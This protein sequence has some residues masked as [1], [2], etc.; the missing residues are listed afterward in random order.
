[1]LKVTRHNFNKSV[2]SPDLFLLVSTASINFSTCQLLYK[3]SFVI[4]KYI[5]TLL[6]L[7]IFWF[8]AVKRF[9]FSVNLLN[10]VLKYMTGTES[11][12]IIFSIN[13]LVVYFLINSVL[14][15]NKLLTEKLINWFCL[16]VLSYKTKMNLLHFLRSTLLSEIPSAF[17]HLYILFIYREIYVEII[18][19]LYIFSL[20]KGQG[21]V[22]IFHCLTYPPHS[23]LPVLIVLSLCTE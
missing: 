4:R 1:M 6:F 14:K 12:P 15:E 3:T 10:S 17:P 20:R 2:I 18:N 7:H 22:M 5:F 13:T 9:F 8:V 16:Y 19:M 11:N 21:T 23:P